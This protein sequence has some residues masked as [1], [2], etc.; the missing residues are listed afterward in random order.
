METVEIQQLFL[1]NQWANRAILSAAQKID[2]LLFT[3]AC[4]CS[5]GSLRG[6]LVDIYGAELVWRMRCDLGVSPSALPSEKDFA[7]LA[8]LQSAWERE[9]E[10]MLAYVNRLEREIPASIRYTNTRGVSFETPLWQILLHLVNHGT[11]FRSEAGIWLSAWGSS[12]GDVDMIAF[13][14]QNQP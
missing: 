4:A 11:Q 1:Y 10:A 5:F 3:A 6:T 9:M 2:P 12:P 14:R 7:D 13:F 8:S